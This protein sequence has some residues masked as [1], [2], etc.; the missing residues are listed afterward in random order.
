MNVD[1]EKKIYDPAWQRTQNPASV[2]ILA[3]QV[4]LLFDIRDLT[5]F[6][7]HLGED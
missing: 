5:L 2:Q 4:Y 1:N 6:I 3:R 7:I